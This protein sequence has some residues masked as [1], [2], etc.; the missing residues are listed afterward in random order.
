[1]KRLLVVD[2]EPAVRSLITASLAGSD[3]EITAVADGSSALDAAKARQPDLI[4]LDVG[5]PGLSGVEVLRRLRSQRSTAS[6]PVVYL[7]GLVPETGPAPDGFL[8]KPFTPA[9]LLRTLG[10]FR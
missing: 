9:S 1:M 3:W 2:D 4:L 6:V 8:A 10:S 5:L 7:T